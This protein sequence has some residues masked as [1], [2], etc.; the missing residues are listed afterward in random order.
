MLRLRAQ[1]MGEH[2]RGGIGVGEGVVRANELDPVPGTDVREAMR[3]LTLGIERARKAQRAQR[4]AQAER[5][6][7]ALGGTLEEGC[8]ERGV[9]SDEL[10]TLQPLGEIGEH[11]GGRWRVAGVAAAD[12][13]QTRGADAVPPAMAWPHQA[14]PPI[15]HH[16]VGVDH[17][18]ADLQQ[19]MPANGEP[20]RLDIDHGKSL[21]EAGRVH[22]WNPRRGV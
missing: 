15:E 19:A 16:T 5:D 22:G 21:G 4:L 8:V 17:H 11:G 2:R 9:V 18:D 3:Q 6:L 14:R 1:E 13:V 7:R 20:G 10:R 12:A